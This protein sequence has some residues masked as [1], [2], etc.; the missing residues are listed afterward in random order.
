M[1]SID[2]SEPVETERAWFTKPKKTFFANRIT[3]KLKLERLV[4]GIK[5]SKNLKIGYRRWTMKDGRERYENYKNHAALFLFRLRG[6][7]VSSYVYP[8]LSVLDG[9]L[10]DLNNS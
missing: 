9:R 3:D 1:E 6:H 5:S 10:S 2:P 7:S 4:T 8:R